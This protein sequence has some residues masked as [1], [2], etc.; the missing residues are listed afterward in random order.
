METLRQNA[1]QANLK[2]NDANAKVDVL[3]GRLQ[4]AENEIR[5][6]AVSGANL[7]LDYGDYLPFFLLFVVS[8][9][10]LILIF[11]QFSFLIGLKISGN[12]ILIIY[13]N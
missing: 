5:N 9:C 2:A 3:A 1:F 10:L 4:I 11:W 6:A 7:L 13:R 12:H 8:F